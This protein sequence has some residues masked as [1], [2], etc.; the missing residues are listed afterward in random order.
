MKAGLLAADG[1]TLPLPRR[2]E[3]FVVH[4]AD[5]DWVISVPAC[6]W[7]VKA[8]A[9]LAKR[10]WGV[11]AEKSPKEFNAIRNWVLANLTAMRLHA[12]RS[13]EGDEAFARDVARVIKA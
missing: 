1:R 9:E 8:L 10:R 5:H 7:T 4:L 3:G 13:S 6:Q 11:D 12:I 2:T